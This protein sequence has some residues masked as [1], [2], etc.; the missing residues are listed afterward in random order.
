M[1][2]KNQKIIGVI[3]LCLVVAG[4]SFY[5]GVKYDSSKNSASQLAN[6]AGFGQN[7]GT[8]GGARGGV[9]AGGFV[10]GQILSMDSTTMTV[11]LN[12]GGSKIVF[13][14]PA[15][16]VA[17]TVNGAITD[18]TTGSQVTVIGTPNSDGSINATSV[19]L[20]P[21]PINNNTVPAK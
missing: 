1:M 2:N 3:V 16:T 9:N 6:R 21:T 20:R 10:S 17:K 4:I 14:S 11:K 7:G 13:Y 18:V 5:G 19:Q 8:R 15:T 12:G